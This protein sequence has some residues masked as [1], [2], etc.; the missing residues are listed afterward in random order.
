M[1]GRQDSVQEMGSSSNTVKDAKYVNTDQVQVPENRFRAVSAK[2]NDIADSIT[3]FGQLQPIIV[4]LK[5]DTSDLTLVDGLH[6]LEACK[7][8]GIKV[9][10]ELSTEFN[11][12]RLREIELEVNIQR[13]DMTW[14][15]KSKAIAELHRLRTLQDPNWTQAQTAQQVSDSVRQADVSN[16]LRIEKMIQIFPELA[17][18]K[19]LSQAMKQAERKAKGMLRVVDVKER[20]IDFVDIAPKLWLGDSVELIKQ[21]P[22]ES[23]HAIITDP[24]F[25]IDFDSRTEGLVSSGSPYEDSAASYRRLL[26]MASD[27][28]RVVKPDGWLI[29]FLGVSWYEEAKAA[30]RAAGFTVDEIP[31][32]W[33][34]TE[35]STFTSRP[36]RWFA[37]GYDM[38]LHCLKGSPTLLRRGN[39][40][41]SIPPVDGHETLAERP[42]ELYVE[43]IQRL[44][45]RGEKVADFFVGSGSCLAAAASLGRDYF[46]IELDPTRR[47]YA[48]NKIKSWTP[49]VK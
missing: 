12:I 48:L 24:P 3:V 32:I 42:V 7:K 23:F 46:G 19:N 47:A 22:D 2:V 43:L 33:D 29:W 45:L 21:V 27:L 49:E 10:Y 35:G 31:I 44:T 38:A 39:N 30:M 18:A 13:M 11:P 20:E 28:Y 41:L 34:R 4:H 25:G 26:S 9:R 1:S 16:A 5:D 6:R 15:E 17:N 14:I 8:L 37:R 40:V 36:D